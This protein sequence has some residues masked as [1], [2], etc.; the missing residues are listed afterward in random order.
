VVV[1]VV[2]HEGRPAGSTGHVKTH[3]AC[4]FVF[5]DGM[6][7]RVTVYTDIDEGRAAAGRLAEQRGLGAK[8][9]VE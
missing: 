3:Q 1:A 2:R 7:V 4:V 9:N 5:V 6:V 8:R